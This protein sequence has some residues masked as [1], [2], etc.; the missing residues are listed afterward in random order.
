[1]T[2]TDIRDYA[3][4]LEALSKHLEDVQKMQTLVTNATRFGLIVHDG[5]TLLSASNPTANN[6][7]VFFPIQVDVEIVR[8]LLLRELAFK[9]QEVARTFDS[10]GGEL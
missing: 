10:L 9:E 7:E 6:A 4:K 3:T 8:K 5:E 2:P 1:M